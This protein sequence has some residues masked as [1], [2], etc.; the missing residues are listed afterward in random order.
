MV[1]GLVSRAN[2]ESLASS[3]LASR[4]SACTELVKGSDLRSDG[5]SLAGSSPVAD[6]LSE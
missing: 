3:N 1:K 4:M 2:G 5:E 6:N